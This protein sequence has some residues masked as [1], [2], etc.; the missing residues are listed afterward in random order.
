MPL[1]IGSRLGSYEIVAPLG[2][3]GMGEVYRA[4]DARLN[5]DVALKVLPDSSLA[6]ETARAQLLREARLAASLNH[7]HICTI[8]EVGETDGEVYFAMEVVNGRQ[9]KELIPA[10][11]LPLET[12]VRYRLQVAGAVGHAHD[13]SIVHRDLKTANVLVTLDGRAKVVDFGIATRHMELDEATRSLQTLDGR[14]V[15]A[16]TLPYIAPEVLR[17]VA[18]DARSDV[19]SLG[20]VLSEMA[21][22]HRPFGGQIGVEL[23]SAILRD[24]PALLPPHVGGARSFRRRTSGWAALT[25]YRRCTPTPSSNTNRPVAYANGCPS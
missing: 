16:G 7:P 10:D 3:G 11:G 22:G 6:E 13:H 4:R 15:V 17:G 25:R 19:W 18:A 1:A 20:V 14:G 8:Y 23:A 9:L 12:V 5:R 2:Q 21:S 24:T